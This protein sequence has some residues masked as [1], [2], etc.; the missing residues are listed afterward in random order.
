MNLISLIL[1]M[2]QG[3][4]EASQIDKSQKTS[5]EFHLGS[6]VKEYQKGLEHSD[7]IIDHCETIVIHLTKG[8]IKEF[9]REGIYAYLW[10]T[11]VKV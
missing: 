11:H 7:R 4:F 5:L 1:V 10:L 9:K 2:F 3:P 6:F 8:T